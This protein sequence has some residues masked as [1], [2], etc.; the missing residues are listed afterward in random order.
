MS[1]TSD[2]VSGA[3]G[4]EQ[5]H[6]PAGTLCT[7]CAAAA[8]HSLLGCILALLFAA[9]VAALL[10]CHHA[11]HV[12]HAVLGEF[13]DFGRVLAAGA[14]APPAMLLAPNRYPQPP[15]TC[16]HE[17]A[18]PHTP[19]HMHAHPCAHARPLARA[20]THLCTHIRNCTHAYPLQ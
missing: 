16:A 8:L 12:V 7:L 15:G 1:A 17:R 2:R 6:P 10:L 3:T 13:E 4:G 5:Q 19:A 20:R 14:S 18:G 11:A 9:C